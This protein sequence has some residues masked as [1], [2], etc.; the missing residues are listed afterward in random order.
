MIVGLHDSPGIFCD[1]VD[2]LPDH[3]DQFYFMGLHSASNDL[4]HL[5]YY[6]MDFVVAG[7]EAFYVFGDNF[8]RCVGP[9]RG[10]KRRLRVIGYP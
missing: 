7:M 6:F 2:L 8:E 4:I 10:F 1:R 3:R 9:V 5:V